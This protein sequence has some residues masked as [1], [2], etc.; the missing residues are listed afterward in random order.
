[1]KACLRV[2]MEIQ[3]PYILSPIKADF[4]DSGLMIVRKFIPNGSLKD[5]IYEKTPKNS[6]MMKYGLRARV[7]KLTI[8]QIKQYGRQILEALNFLAEKGFVMGKLKQC[9]LV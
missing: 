1:M 5:A 2:L 4:D 7:R 8:N 9:M 6:M 3:H